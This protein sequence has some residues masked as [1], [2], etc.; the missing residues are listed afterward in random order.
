ME[1]EGRRE[2]NNVEDRRGQGGGGG[3]GMGR[4]GGLGIGSIAI[5]LVASLVFGINPMTVLGILDGVGG[6]EPAPQVSQ[7][8]AKALPKDDQ[9]GRFVSTVLA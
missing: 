3:M 2:S 5:A 8:P 1:T 9:M 7:G 6:G 4:R